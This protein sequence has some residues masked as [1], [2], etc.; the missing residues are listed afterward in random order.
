MPGGDVS[1]LLVGT[2]GFPQVNTYVIQNSSAILF[3]AHTL[4]GVTLFAKFRKQHNAS[5]CTI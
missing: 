4:E 2:Y 3:H 1:A 5:D